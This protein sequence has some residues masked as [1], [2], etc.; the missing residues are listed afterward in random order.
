MIAPRHLPRVGR[1]I[2]ATGTDMAD[3]I[4]KRGF[5]PK[6]GSHGPGVY[7]GSRPELVEPWIWRRRYGDVDAEALMG[8]VEPEDLI[9]LGDYVTTPH[10]YQKQRLGVIEAL[11]GGKNVVMR[12]HP[13]WGDFYV[14]D[15][16]F[17]TRS[18]REFEADPTN[19]YSVLDGY[20]E[21]LERYLRNNPHLHTKANHLDP[22]SSTLWEY[23]NRL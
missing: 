23:L 13:T 17:A 9:D 20:K 11:R 7:A 18:L 2:H 21:G 16:T 19:F 22:N 5:S 3:V 10:L 1:W 15:P 8:H 12:N 14:L 4:R 6:A